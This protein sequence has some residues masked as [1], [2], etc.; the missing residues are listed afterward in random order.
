VISRGNIAKTETGTKPLMPDGLESILNPQTAGIVIAWIR[1]KWPRRMEN[2][3]D[4][5]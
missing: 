4:Y 1:A 3:L 5:Q 2:A